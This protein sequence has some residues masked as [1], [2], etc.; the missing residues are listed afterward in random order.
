[1]Q[2]EFADQL[3]VSVDRQP[4]DKVV[5]LDVVDR[6]SCRTV[7]F[8]RLTY[9]DVIDRLPIPIA[10]LERR[11]VCRDARFDMQLVRLDPQSQD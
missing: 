2:C 6:Q 1:M 3:C 9:R 4:K 5:P 10:H 11:P 8:P 7:R